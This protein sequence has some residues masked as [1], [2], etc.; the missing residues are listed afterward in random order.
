[1]K[2]AI[3]RLLTTLLA[4]VVIFT[5]GLSY[6]GSASVA[7]AAETTSVNTLK[8]LFP[9]GSVIY[10]DSFP[11]FLI[12][13]DNAASLAITEGKNDVKFRITMSDNKSAQQ[14]IPALRLLFG[15]IK[16]PSKVGDSTSVSSNIKGISKEQYQELVLKTGNKDLYN[17]CTIL[18]GNDKSKLRGAFGSFISALST[19]IQ[20][21]NEAGNTTG[22]SGYYIFLDKA[23]EYMTKWT[24]MITSLSFHSY[25][26][27]DSPAYPGS[28]T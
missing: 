12:S 26:P 7:L 23:Q 16:L 27:C 9:I 6:S 8:N 2:H 5:S 21:T 14:S 24:G 13:F 18:T 11:G 20:T 28:H 4:S 10:S 1:M 17:F 19:Y 15:N 22:V 3:K 25:C